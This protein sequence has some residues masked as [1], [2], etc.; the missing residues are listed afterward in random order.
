MSYKQLFLLFFLGFNLQFTYS[1]IAQQS[2]KAHHGFQ[3]RTGFGYFQPGGISGSGEILFSEVGYQLD[4][5]VTLGFGLGLGSTLQKIDDL[6]M[7]GFQGEKF[8]NTFHIWKLLIERRSK[9]PFGSLVVGTALLLQV[10]RERE[11]F[12]R[13]IAESISETGELIV[14]IGDNPNNEELGISLN[15]GYE[16]PVS[17]NFFFGL[18]GEAYI[19][20]ASVFFDSYIIAPVFAIRF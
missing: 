2:E 8:Q 17:K 1:A 19:H 11:P 16:I 6:G 13:R 14:G 15:A 9:L 12:A 4:K 20:T 7:S 18:R 5:N 3:I 10:E